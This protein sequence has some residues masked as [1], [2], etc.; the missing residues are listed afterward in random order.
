MKKRGHVG[1]LNKLLDD[2]DA[3]Y[4]AG[5]SAGLAEAEAKEDKFVRGGATQITTGGRDGKPVKATRVAQTAEAA[6]GGGT[7]PKGASRR[8]N[9]RGG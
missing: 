2:V 7:I 1:A 6:E 9:R 8:G 5:D 4:D 3:A